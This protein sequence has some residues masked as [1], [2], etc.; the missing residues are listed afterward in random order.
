MTG[1]AKQGST[2]IITAR[3]PKANR[4]CI[5]V[6]VPQCHYYS[7]THLDCGN[8]RAR[9]KILLCSMLSPP[10][11]A[12][13]RRAIATTAVHFFLLFS[14]TNTAARAPASIVK[15][16]R[17]NTRT[18]AATARPREGNT[19]G[20]RLPRECGKKA[21]TSTPQRRSPVGLFALYLRTPNGV[22]PGPPTLPL[23]VRR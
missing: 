23:A 22:S 3:P 11:A 14:Q 12:P 9:H 1:K 4:W 6:S 5:A 17:S 19:A 10:I 8:P 18:C 15:H 16:V 21:P 13:H 2:G 7:V 20:S